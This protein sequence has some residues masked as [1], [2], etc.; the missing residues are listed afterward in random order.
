MFKRFSIGQRIKVDEHGQY[1][2]DPSPTSE[3]TDPISPATS[4]VVLQPGPSRQVQLQPP[5]DASQ[6]QRPSHEETSPLGHQYNDVKEF[7][8]RLKAL[9]VEVEQCQQKAFG[10]VAQGRVKGWMVVGKNMRFLP[11]A[12]VVE[13]RTKEDVLWNNVG[14]QSGEMWFWIKIGC[15]GLVLAAISE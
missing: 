8:T 7:R 5:P 1:V 14:R 11:F 10:Q 15:I 2:P 12:Q 9:N 3:H 4:E 6:S 13:G